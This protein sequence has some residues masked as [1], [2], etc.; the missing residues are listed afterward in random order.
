MRHYQFAQD[1]IDPFV[2]EEHCI[3]A[4]KTG[5]GKCL[6]RHVAQYEYCAERPTP[7]GKNRTELCYYNGGHQLSQDESGDEYTRW[8][9]PWRDDAIIYNKYLRLI[10]PNSKD[11]IV[12]SHTAVRNLC[13]PICRDYRDW[14]LPMMK[15]WR[16]TGKKHRP[17]ESRHQLLPN[18][19]EI[20][21]LDGGAGEWPPDASLA[22]A[23]KKN[24]YNWNQDPSRASTSEAMLLYW[25]R[26][27]DGGSEMPLFNPDFPRAP[28]SNETGWAEKGFASDPKLV[29]L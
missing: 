23:S 12:G 10:N 11:F 1:G 4:T 3:E 2:I 16:P 24:K 20:P 9:F 27:L 19:K 5:H 28:W 6:D 13:E 26:V 15:K 8:D 18:I 17:V 7:D 25:P 22:D 29:Q 21:N 14:N